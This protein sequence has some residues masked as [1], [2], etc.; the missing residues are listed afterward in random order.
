MAGT[1]TGDGGGEVEEGGGTVKRWLFTVCLRRA[2]E[3]MRSSVFPTHVLAHERVIPILAMI[4]IAT[5]AAGRH[6]SR[7]KTNGTDALEATHDMQP[8]PE[9][10]Q[11]VR[12]HAIEAR[13]E[14]TGTAESCSVTRDGSADSGGIT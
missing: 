9:A 5:P 11:A 6:S 4:R 8:R 2:V 12:E 7:T 3:E 1:G 10:V 13:R 14:A